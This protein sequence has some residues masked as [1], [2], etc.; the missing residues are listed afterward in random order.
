MSGEEL[1]DESQN[2][3]ML[4]EDE[5]YQRELCPS[6]FLLNSGLDIISFLTMEY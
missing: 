6:V 5:P 2:K 3:N 4:A 1:S